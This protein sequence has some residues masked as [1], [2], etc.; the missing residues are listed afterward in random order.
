M[1]TPSILKACYYDNFIPA[2][3]GLSPSLKR[4]IC[5]INNFEIILVEIKNVSKR[6][7][8]AASCCCSIIYY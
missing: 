4:Y 1:A 3:T 7:Y 2:Q 8:N 6:F 5:F